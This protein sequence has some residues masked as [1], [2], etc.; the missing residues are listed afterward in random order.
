VRLPGWRRATYAL[1]SICSHELAEA[2]TDPVP[3]KDG[4]TTVRVRSG[5]CRL[6]EQKAGP[7]TVQLLWSNRTRVASDSL[8]RAPHQHL[9]SARIGRRD[10]NTL[11]A[12][13]A[14]REAQPEIARRRKRSYRS[15]AAAGLRQDPP[16]ARRSTKLRLGERLIEYP[17]RSVA[18]RTLSSGTPPAARAAA[19]CSHASPDP[20]ACICARARETPRRPSSASPRALVLGERRDGAALREVARLGDASRR[21]SYRARIAYP[22]AAETGPPERS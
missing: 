11:L 7:Y 2:V 5:L 1:T 15:R 8:L 6:A 19:R 13:A 17:P 18:R 16:V 20:A 12:A 9:H 10:A 4:T 14:P 3:R 21:S 22:V